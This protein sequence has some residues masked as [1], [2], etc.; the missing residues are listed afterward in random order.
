MASAEERKVELE[1][2]KQKLAEIRE[3]RRR[4]EEQ[5]RLNM[6]RSAQQENAPG[7]KVLIKFV[8]NS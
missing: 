8:M 3:D 4:R 7:F 6:L 1:R 2:K 5:R